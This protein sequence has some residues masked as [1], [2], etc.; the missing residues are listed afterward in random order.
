MKKIGI[1]ETLPF[2]ALTIVAIGSL[3]FPTAEV[4]ADTSKYVTGDINW[5][6][7]ATALVFLM[8]PGLAFFYGGMVN[9]KNVLSTMIK[10]FVAAGIVT[11]LW[12]TV[13]YGMSFGTSLGGVIGNPMSHLFYKNVVNG[14]PWV[15]APTIPLTLFSLFQLMFAIITP[16]LVVG[17][18]AE[19][20]KFTSYVLFIVLFCCLFYLLFSCLVFFSLLLFSLLFSAL[21]FS[22]FLISSLL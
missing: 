12:L 11:V 15:G 22:S 8:T 3:F 9:R 6:L 5:V 13:G 19:R 21:L 2:I 1:R 4:F 17:A 16:A 18:V 7:V 10:S 20:V 14:A